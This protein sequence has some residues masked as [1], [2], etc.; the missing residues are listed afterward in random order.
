MNKVHWSAY[1]VVVEKVTE[2]TASDSRQERLVCQA[3][4]EKSSQFQRLTHLFPV[5]VPRKCQAEF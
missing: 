2:R 4:K 5:W 3:E 1:K